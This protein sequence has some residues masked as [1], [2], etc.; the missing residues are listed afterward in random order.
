MHAAKQNESQFSDGTLRLPGLLWT[1]FEG[2]GPLLLE[3]P[4]ISL[5]P[6]VVR[7]LPAIFSRINRSRKMPRQI[8]VSTH[9]EEMLRDPASVRRRCCAWS[10]AL[11]A[12]CCAG[13]RSHRQSMR[14]G[15]TAADVLMPK[16]APNNIQ[17]MVL[18]FP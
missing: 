5:H 7:R 10:P 2:D 11:T 17:Q 14:A 15:L 6:E 3:E 9:S 12:R 1:S 18:E 4:E 8:I 13:R 16:T